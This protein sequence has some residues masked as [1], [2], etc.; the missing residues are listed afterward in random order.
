MS[1]KEPTALLPL[2]GE[3]PLQQNNLEL[4]I[5]Q[6]RVLPGHRGTHLQGLCCWQVWAA[7]DLCDV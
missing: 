5:S 6:C 4:P 1:E 2:Q 7:M 3:P